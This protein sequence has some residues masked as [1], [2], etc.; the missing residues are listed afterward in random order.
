MGHCWV[1]IHVRI[2]LPL[3]LQVAAR[4]LENG[5][6]ETWPPT[7]VPVCNSSP[8]FIFLTVSGSF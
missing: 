1:L 6:Q 5:P 8:G 3:F 2:Q 4:K 7:S